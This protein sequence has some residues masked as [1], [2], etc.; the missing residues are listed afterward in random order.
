MKFETAIKKLE[1]ISQKIDSE[2]IDLDQALTLYAEGISMIKEC[3]RL[4]EEAE[5]KIN[6]V[7]EL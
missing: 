4:L 2:E 5:N 1:E 3:N 6:E 7:N